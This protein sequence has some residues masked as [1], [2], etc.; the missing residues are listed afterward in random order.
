MET[1]WSK[2]SDEILKIGL[3]LEEIG[4]RNWAL[5]REQASIALDQFEDEGIAILGGDV[6]EIQR[7]SLRMNY[8]NWYCDRKKGESDGDF[9]HRS[10]AQARKYIFSYGL[11]RDIECFFAIVPES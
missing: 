10:I 1:I 7:E 5:N 4:V 8:D 3:S 6:Y 11:S 2:K 9:V